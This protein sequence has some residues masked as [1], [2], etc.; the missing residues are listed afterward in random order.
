DFQ[1]QVLIIVFRIEKEWADL[2][3]IPV[4]QGRLFDLLAIEQGPVGV[5]EI[6]DPVVAVYLLDARVRARDRRMV[7]SEIVTDQ[8]ANGQSLAIDNNRIESDIFA[9]DY[10][11]AHSDWWLVV[12]GWSTSNY[13]S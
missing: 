11:F 2:N 6:E 5:R 13:L 9:D 12:G 8:S 1:S 10:I 7:E 4:G 3:Q